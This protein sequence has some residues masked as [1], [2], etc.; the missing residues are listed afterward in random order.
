MELE[1]GIVVNEIEE[2]AGAEH[3]AGDHLVRVNG[4]ALVVHHAELDQVD[5]LVREHLAVDAQVLVAAQREEHRFG[6]PADAGLKRGAIGNELRDVRG[7][8]MMDR[9]DPALLV[10]GQRVRGLDDGVR[11]ADVKEGIAQR[12]GRL[13]VDLDDEVARAVGAG[14]ADVDARSQAHVAVIVGRCALDE[15]DV[16]GN[17]AAAE[18]ALDFV[19]ENGDVVGAAFLNRAPD[20][21][22]D[23]HGAVPEDAFVL[24]QRVIGRAHGGHVEDLDVAEFGSALEQRGDESLGF[25]AALVDQNAVSGFDGLE[26][27]GGGPDLRA[28]AFDPVHGAHAF[29]P[30]AGS[31]STSASGR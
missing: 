31:A 19:Q 30:L 6:N 21:G 8:G 22:A 4:L 5:N 18:Q 10:L 27:L 3:E 20:V 13:V 16:D 17:R 24:G 7:D 28:V 1:D 14:Q 25:R 2:L 15:R 12:A 9:R 11:L 26:G 23:E 29:V